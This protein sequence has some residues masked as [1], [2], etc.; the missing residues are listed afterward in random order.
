MIKQFDGALI[1]ELREKRKMSRED[2][3]VELA[4]LDH[5]VHS[6]TIKSWED[7]ET[8]P[9]ADDVPFLASALGVTLS[10]FYTDG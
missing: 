5:R 3:A 9:D 8:H 7:G 10:A 6:Q 1:K 4:K 2:L